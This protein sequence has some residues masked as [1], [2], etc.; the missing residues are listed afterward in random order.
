MCHSIRCYFTRERSPRGGSGGLGP[1]RRGMSSKTPFNDPTPS[2]AR[3]RTGG[4]RKDLK[5]AV[6]RPAPQITSMPP[7]KSASSGSYSVAVPMAKTTPL[8]DPTQILPTISMPSHKSTAS[9]AL[10]VGN[11]IRLEDIDV[12]PSRTRFE[13][14][15]TRTSR[16]GSW[17]PRER[18]FKTFKSRRPSCQGPRHN[19]HNRTP[20]YHQP[21][22]QCSANSHLLRRLQDVK[23]D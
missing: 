3:S 22:H 19:S 15:G 2:T 23:K 21:P 8:Q 4:P 16:P 7:H 1:F 18:N 11:Q 12:N 20:K 14:H 10:A 13:D 6:H 9:G 17:G 5:T